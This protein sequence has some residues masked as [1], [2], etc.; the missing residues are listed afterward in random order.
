[1]G[2]ER[3]PVP[4]LAFRQGAHRKTINVQTQERSGRFYEYTGDELPW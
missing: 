3:A 2:G 1:M 4:A